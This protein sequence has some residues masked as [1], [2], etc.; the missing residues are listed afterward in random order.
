M[1]TVQPRVY[2]CNHRVSAALPNAR[3]PKRS[4]RRS[5]NTARRSTDSRWPWRAGCECAC[6]H[7]RRLRD[8]PTTHFGLARA[9][10]WTWWKFGAFRNHSG[11]QEC[12][13]RS[14]PQGPE[15][16]EVSVNLRAVNATPARHASPNTEA[17]FSHSLR[18][19][20]E[21]MLLNL[22]LQRHL[23]N[24]GSSPRKPPDPPTPRP[25][26][27]PPLW[28]FSSGPGGRR[29]CCRPPSLNR[30]NSASSQAE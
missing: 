13:R 9:K 15:A 17:D 29:R 28:T 5:G 3:S 23:T 21:C 8:S 16:A 18:K 12:C 26:P 14:H 27:P 2:T 30:S 1:Q 19:Q 6:K 22:L 20:F 11:T 7:D 4:C 24:R 25:P 10:S